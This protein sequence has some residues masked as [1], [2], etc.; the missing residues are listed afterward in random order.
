MASCS[1]CRA[2]KKAAPTGSPEEQKRQA[3]VGQD[4]D[5]GRATLVLTDISALS[6]DDKQF[7]QHPT[8][9]NYNAGDVN[10]AIQG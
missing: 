2:K 10:N 1:S 5:Q 9:T 4:L 6:T 7:V 8:Q 3:L